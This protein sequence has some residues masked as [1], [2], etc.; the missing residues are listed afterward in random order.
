[1]FNLHRET[2]AI[3]LAGLKSL[4]VLLSGM[5]YSM[6]EVYAFSPDQMLCY[7]LG[8]G[9]AVSGT[10]ASSTCQKISLNF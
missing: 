9:P 3:N 1:M 7:P 8:R 2:W 5:K 6:L 10:K 4:Y